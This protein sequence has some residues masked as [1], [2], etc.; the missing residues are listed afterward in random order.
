VLAD[1]FGDGADAAKRSVTWIN[2]QRGHLASLV[3]CEGSSIKIIVI[4]LT[5]KTGCKVAPYYA[6]RAARPVML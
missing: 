6:G 3:L 1:I 4:Q 5:I 2:C